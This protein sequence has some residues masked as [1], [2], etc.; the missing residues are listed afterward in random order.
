MG[1]IQKQLQVGTLVQG[2]QKAAPG[3]AGG[4]EHVGIRQKSPVPDLPGSWAQSHHSDL[5]PHPTKGAS[6]EG[7]GLR[8]LTPWPK[9]IHILL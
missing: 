4:G 1:G 6:K 7:L 5:V 8:L 2:R 3:S 9:Y